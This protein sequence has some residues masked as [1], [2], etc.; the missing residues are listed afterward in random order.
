M[1]SNRP[2][3]WLLRLTPAFGLSG[4]F[5]LG[6][7]LTAAAQPHPAPAPGGERDQQARVLFEQG[8]AAYDDGN[9]RDAWAAFH[10]AYRLSARPELLFNIGQTADRM[11]HDADAIKAFSLYLK[12]LPDAPNR[13]DVENRVRA[14]R[15]H[16]DSENAAA[17]E[18]PPPS[19][20]SQPSP[21]PSAAG[22]WPRQEPYAKAPAPPRVREPRRGFY[23]RV[24]PGFG[25][26]TDSIST[27]YDGE[28]F[29][30]S[31]YGYGF[32][33]DLAA[34]WAVAPGFVIGGALLFDWTFSPTMTFDTG[35]GYTVRSELEHANLISFGPFIDWY[36]ARQS[37][38]LHIQG[39][40]GIAVL[41]YEGVDF[42]GSALGFSG[43]LG[44]GWEWQL[45]G[46]FAL[47]VMVRLTGAAL[48][49][50]DDTHALFSPSLLLSLTYF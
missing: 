33:L 48:A 30:A 29:D 31:L 49:N 3:S 46:P 23:L 7:C 44:G 1:N 21:P 9:Y 37:L 22:T 32:T 11:G 34:G 47:G 15:E 16:N 28:E 18:P 36:P 35:V 10:E 27:T 2:L 24:A 38:G 4:L 8:R 17:P 41:S 40:L 13:R 19:V 12:R 5:C 6:L 43:F 39:G 50:T 20:P 25:L 26:R 45:A 42:S 14:L